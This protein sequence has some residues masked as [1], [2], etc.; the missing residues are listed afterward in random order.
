M[1]SLSFW[2]AAAG[3]LVLALFLL[4]P[5]LLRKRRVTAPA[6]RA[7]EIAVYRQRL[8]EL[9]ADHARGQLSEAQ[10]QIARDELAV[11]LTADLAPLAEEAPARRSGRH[12]I[13][14][15]VVVVVTLGLSVLLYESLGS[16]EAAQ[17]SIAAGLEQQARQTAMQ[18]AVQ[19]LEAR[20][21][22]TPEDGRGWQL[23]GR[24]YLALNQ[25]GNASE[26][27]ARAKLLLGDDPDLLVDYAR[28]L[29]AT[30]DGQ[31]A[32][33]PQALLEQVLEKRPGHPMAL[34]L[35]AAAYEQQGDMAKAK[36]YL[37][38]LEEQTEPDSAAHRWV[39]EALA[40]LSDTPDPAL[41]RVPTSAGAAGASIQV[42]VALAPSLRP[43]AAPD[44]TVF[45]FARATEGPPMPLAVVRRRVA[46]LPVTVTLDDS[47]AM[48]PQFR[49][50]G[51]AEVRIGA[52]VSKSGDP[53]PQPGDLQG[54]AGPAVAV[55][56][57]RATAV[58]VEI[59]RVLP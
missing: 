13:T 46:D 28:A 59:N 57:T 50:S 39:R 16:R 54:D 11:G 7:A 48:A 15:S 8:A 14:A 18:A 4:L 9:N 34:Y 40:G 35:A 47:Q 3:M 53:M 42:R 38:R 26:A 25:P 24:S 2:I 1:T 20:L 19:S 49:L 10:F 44:D 51:Y 22:S 23:L 5:P 6:H 29:A 32:G 45:I 37:E 30:Q 43:R 31:L 33:R 58:N 55:N 21:R 27:M 17:A 12:G 36:A 41:R 56:E 52:R